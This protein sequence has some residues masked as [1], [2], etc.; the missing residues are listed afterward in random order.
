MNWRYLA[1][2]NNGL[3]TETVFLPR[4]KVQDVFTRTNPFQRMAGVT[5]I[6]AR[7]AA[8]VSSTVTQLWD[9]AEEDGWAWLEWLKPRTSVV[10]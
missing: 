5:T 9:V 1:I 4:A 10:Q 3:S 7:T 2:H 6:E 8:G